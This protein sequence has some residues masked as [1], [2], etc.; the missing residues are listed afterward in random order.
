M[1]TKITH[2]PCHALSFVNNWGKREDES[3]VPQIIIRGGLPKIHFNHIYLFSVIS[4]VQLLNRVQ[5]F[6]TP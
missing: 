4:S 3:V 2:I 5:L 1:K 6:A